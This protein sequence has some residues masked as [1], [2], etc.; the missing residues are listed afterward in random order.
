MSIL[1]ETSGKEVRRQK[2]TDL[3]HMVTNQQN[4][5]YILA[6]GIVMSPA[7]F[8]GKHYED[9]LNLYPG[10]VP[11]FRN[12]K[13]KMS[14]PNKT[15]E[16]VTNERKF[17][18][19]CIASFNVSSLAGST[20]SLKMLTKKGNKRKRNSKF[21]DFKK[22][23]DEIALLVRTPLPVSLLSSI[24]FRNLEEKEAFQATARNT[25]NV[26]LASIE[27]TVDESLF[28]SDPDFELPSK[29]SSAKDKDPDLFPEDNV[30]VHGQAI[31]GVLAMLYHL[32]NRSDFGL[33]TFHVAF[34]NASEH[35]KELVQKDLILAEL[36]LW[37]DTGR[38]S[39]Q[40][41][42]RAK[43]F[44]GTIKSLIDSQK[45]QR[46]QL[47]VPVVL[48]YLEEQLQKTDNEF[49]PR[50]EEVILEMRNILGLGTSTI[51]QLFEKHTG[52]LSRALLLFCLREHCSGLLEF[53]HPLLS[54]TDYSV[55]GILFGVRDGWLRFP[56]ELRRADLAQYVSYRMSLAEHQ[57][58]ESHLTMAEP[59]KP[60]PLRD[61]FI[62]SD[63][64][65]DTIRKEIALNLIE[66]CNWHDCVQTS[67]TLASPIPTGSIII[68]QEG[69]EIIIPTKITRSMEEIDEECFLKNLEQWKAVPLEIELELHEKFTA[70]ETFGKK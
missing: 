5:L 24:N 39:E 17:L 20:G 41:D 6:S 60:K 2:Q 43:L 54:D 29:E 3:W 47:A 33:A 48:S 23:S 63:G 18:S 16:S 64:K 38:I 55:A 34:D 46:P 30:P 62:T 13:N 61:Y 31:G 14:I 7:G 11:L 58:Q 28:N 69:L 66:R 26:D 53:T 19:P 65:W 50:L 57:Q 9:T 67:I 32:A 35:E 4:M 27:L 36:A 22:N 44:W 52:A 21:A 25:A 12:V 70:S 59:Q 49:R 51:T 10:Y 56:K 42:I 68:A 45:E 15:L 1:K 8:R 37:L 40:V